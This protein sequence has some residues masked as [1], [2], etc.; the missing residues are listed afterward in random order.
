MG[1]LDH[2]WGRE[3]GRNARASDESRG[4]KRRNDEKKE[5]GRREG[6][7]SEMKRAMKSSYAETER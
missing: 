4:E 3:E 6:E 5:G 2:L 1:W 7:A